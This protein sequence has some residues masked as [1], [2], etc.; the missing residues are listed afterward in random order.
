MQRGGINPGLLRSV[1]APARSGER[2]GER[3]TVSADHG[4]EFAAREPS[5]Q[6]TRAEQM[7]VVAF[8]VGVDDAAHRAIQDDA[9]L[10]DASKAFQCRDRA[11]RAVE[12]AAVRH[13][14]NVRAG[15][16]CGGAPRCRP[17]LSATKRSDCRD[18]R[19]SQ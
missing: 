14:V 4:F 3:V 1:E 9:F 7:R 8:F 5:G 11:Q 12:L 16:D 18:R 10:M 2:V 15:P 19:S 13:G 6:S 17:P